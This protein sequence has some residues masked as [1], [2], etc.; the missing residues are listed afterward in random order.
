MPFCG[1][2]FGTSNSTLACQIQDRMELVAV[3]ENSRS[4]SQF[5]LL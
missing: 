5:D 2:D 3:E 1:L 4:S